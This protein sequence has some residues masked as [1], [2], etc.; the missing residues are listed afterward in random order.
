MEDVGDGSRLVGR[1]QE[2]DRMEGMRW[3][4]VGCEWAVESVRLAGWWVGG[5]AQVVDCFFFQ[6]EDGIRDYK[7]T[8]VQTCA[9]PILRDTLFDFWIKPYRYETDSKSQKVYLSS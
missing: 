6:A 5:T 9:L 7:V 3:E 4:S 8:G 1:V 2:G